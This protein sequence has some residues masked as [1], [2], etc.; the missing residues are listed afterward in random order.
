MPRHFF[1]QARDALTLA[2]TKL[3]TRKVRTALT[4]VSMAVFAIVL[5]IA[6]SVL[7][8]FTRF[9]DSTVQMQL[10]D[11]H[12]ASAYGPGV[13]T[14]GKLP[15][16]TKSLEQFRKDNANAKGLREVY[17]ETQA[18][19]GDSSTFA[20]FDVLK[21]RTPE[22]DPFFHGFSPNLVARSNEMLRPLL[23]ENQSS[24][25][26]DG[27]FPVFVSRD[28]VINAHDS[29]LSQIKD[30][31]KRRIRSDEILK[32]IVGQRGTITLKKVGMFPTFSDEQPDGK[33]P[34]P[35]TTMLSI[36]VRVVGFE[37]Q[38]GT[39]FDSTANAVS[40]V[41]PLEAIQQND[42]Y[43]TLGEKVSVLY[44]SFESGAQ[45]DAFVKSS[46]FQSAV[47]GDPVA[48][49][50]E[51]FSVLQRVYNIAVI[52]MLVL[53]AIPV[54][55]TLSK[56]LADSQRENGVFRAI[57]AR[58]SN[59][60]GI[61]GIYNFLLVLAAYVI[62]LAVGFA[63]CAWLDAKFA[64]RVVNATRTAF[65]IQGD[66]RLVQFNPAHQVVIFVGLCASA[67]IG[68]IIPL[69]RSLRRDPIKA[70]RDE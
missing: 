27:I 26:V 57:G 19:A 33:A 10:R 18:N 40:Y 6:S 3:R 15:N 1:A 5:V 4:L 48:E 25:V 20:E 62:A 14:D 38:T 29:E 51:A 61:Y 30:K 43:S 7:T 36:P 23:S 47:Y 42:R 65:A 54:M 31:E 59:I 22:D 64:D 9:A 34:E 63:I 44:P 2:I 46:P 24:D 13:P 37:Y 32:S 66:L 16:V 55:V 39:V 58:N 21:K 50:K 45:R 67:L 53:M 17:V 60:A 12:L 52:I 56:I 35:P 28:A 11:L 49:N 70:L 41:L 8:G 68:S 69:W